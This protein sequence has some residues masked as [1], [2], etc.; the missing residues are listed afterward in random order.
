LGRWGLV[1]L[2]ETVGEG[3]HGVVNDLFA[4]NRAALAELRLSPEAGARAEVVVNV[5]LIELHGSPP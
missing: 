3:L 2:A 5:L 4:V 1:D